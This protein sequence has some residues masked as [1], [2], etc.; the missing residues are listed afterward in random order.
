MLVSN[1]ERVRSYEIWFEQPDELPVETLHRLRIECKYLR[2]NLEFLASLLG[3]ESNEI[4]ALLR[5]LQDDLGDLNDA[6][7]SKQL[8]SAGENGNDEKAVARYEWAQEK[9]IDKLRSQT[10][11]DFGHFVGKAN[12]GHLLSALANI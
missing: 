10:R 7:V 6:V 9:I 8:V 4:I 11:D 12:R 2:Y 3:R 1:F 5:K